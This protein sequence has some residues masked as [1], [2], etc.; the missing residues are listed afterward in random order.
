MSSSLSSCGSTAVINA[1]ATLPS[2]IAY[3]EPSGLLSPVMDRH[4][5][6]VDRIRKLRFVIAAM[7]MADPTEG[8]GGQTNSPQPRVV[9]K[10]SSAFSAALPTFRQAFPTTPWVFLY[11]NIDEVVMSHVSTSRNSPLCSRTMRSPPVGLK[12]M[13]LPKTL[14]SMTE[15]EYCIAYESFL[16]DMAITSAEKDRQKKRAETALLVAY[17]NLQAD[18]YAKIVPHF[19]VDDI[20]TATVLERTAK[21]FGTYAKLSHRV[22]T[23]G[24][25]GQ[26]EMCLTCLVYSQGE[27]RHTSMIP[28]ASRKTSHRSFVRSSLPYKTRFCKGLSLYKA[29]HSLPSKG[30]KLWNKITV[31]HSRRNRKVWQTRRAK[32]RKCL[33][34]RAMHSTRRSFTTIQMRTTG[35]FRPSGHSGRRILNWLGLPSEVCD[36]AKSCV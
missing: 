32:T 34:P 26:L 25:E 10:L 21:S 5:K 17:P 12:A 6:E 8:E 3:S 2:V 19:G 13:T 11:R 7:G 9:I 28:K 31:K 20:P 27:A 18:F 35:M 24:S 33:K 16:A 22:S 36:T 23:R 14:E 29:A 30:Q 4:M 1:F 15:Q